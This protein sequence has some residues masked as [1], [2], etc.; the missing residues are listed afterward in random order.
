M[1]ESLD[2]EIPEAP[3]RDRLS[4]DFR[5]G[6]T[7]MMVVLAVAVVV[8]ALTD[9]GGGKTTTKTTI[10]TKAVPD[11]ALRKQL[12][13]LGARVAR[14]ESAEAALQSSVGTLGKRVGALSARL[15]RVKPGGT[16]TAGSAQLLSQLRALTTQVQT[17]NQCL[18]QMQKEIDDIQAFGLNRQPLRKRVSGACYQLLQPRY[19]G[20]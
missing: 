16:T 17:T 9:S 6:V 3:G 19:A 12:T 7:L 14:A 15:D 1:D 11:P 4:L 18:F 10:V 2:Q 8:L 13:A 5:V 20:Q